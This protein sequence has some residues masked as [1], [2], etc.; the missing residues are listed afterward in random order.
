[1]LSEVRHVVVNVGLE[2]HLSTRM[3]GQLHY[4]FCFCPQEEQERMYLV[5]A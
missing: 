3:T 1:M 4:C 2:E 5:S